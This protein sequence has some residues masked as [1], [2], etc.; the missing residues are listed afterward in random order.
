[1]ITLLLPAGVINRKRLNADLSHLLID[2][3]SFQKLFI[4]GI[5]TA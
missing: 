1:M 3:S 4:H 2:N 5:V